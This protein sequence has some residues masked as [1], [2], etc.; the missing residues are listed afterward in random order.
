MM[1]RI[2]TTDGREYE[3]PYPIEDVYF[4]YRYREKGCR[5][6]LLVQDSEMRPL[7]VDCAEIDRERT[8]AD[9][10]VESSRGFHFPGDDMGHAP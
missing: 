3:A 4:L 5:I 7:L 2:Y 1:P 8:F 6:R 10:I 9:E